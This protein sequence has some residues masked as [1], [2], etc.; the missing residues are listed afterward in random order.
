MKKQDIDKRSENLLSL[1]QSNKGY[2]KHEL[3]EELG[4]SLATLGRDLKS[5]KS[6]MHVIRCTDGK[7]YYEKKLDRYFQHKKYSAAKHKAV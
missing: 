6:R 3:S 7:Y 5:L 2:T 4:I 1:L